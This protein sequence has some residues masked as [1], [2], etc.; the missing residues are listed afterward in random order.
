M[1][2]LQAVLPGLNGTSRA[3]GPQAGGSGGVGEFEPAIQVPAF[4]NAKQHACGEG[5][6][7]TIGASDGI[8]WNADGLP[9]DRFARPR[10]DDA[11][12]WKV[13]CHESQP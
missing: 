12:A 11:A 13:Y 9:F 2:E 4:V 8:G 10:H 7:R 6:P 1:R 3:V 5:V